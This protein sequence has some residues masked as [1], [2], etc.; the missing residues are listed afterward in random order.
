MTLLSRYPLNGVLKFDLTKQD[1]WKL[2]VYCAVQYS[3]WYRLTLYCATHDYVTS[4]DFA[5]VHYWSVQDAYCQQW[6]YPAAEARSQA[7]HLKKRS[8]LRSRKQ[9]RCRPGEC[10]VL[11][12]FDHIIHQKSRRLLSRNLLFLSVSAIEEQRQAGRHFQQHIWTWCMI[13]SV[14]PTPEKT[15]C[16]IVQIQEPKGLMWIWCHFFNMCCHSWSQFMGDMCLTSKSVQCC[17]D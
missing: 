8:D 15:H 7:D 11:R 5:F 4:P 13:R 9:A 10:L 17:D 16:L 3:F 6:W 1:V 12:G 2:S 14:S